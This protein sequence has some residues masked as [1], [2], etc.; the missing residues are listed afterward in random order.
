MVVH[1]CKKCGQVFTYKSNYIR[2]IN[3]KYACIEKY[4]TLCMVC[5]K[6][7]AFRASLYR[8]RKTCKET[9]DININN[10]LMTDQR[11]INNN[12]NVDGDVKVVKF[13]NENLSYISNDLYKH[14]LGRGI[15]SV[16]ELVNHTHFNE[17]HPE[18][19]NIYISNIKSNCLVLYDG[20]KWIITKHDEKL[21]DMIYAKSDFLY[22][23]FK[24]LESQM[25]PLDASKFR[26][27]LDI[28]DD[29][30]T[31]E[32][33]KDNLQLR[34]YNCRHMP[35]QIRK[36]MEKLKKAIYIPLQPVR[37]DDDLMNDIIHILENA[38]RTKLQE[39]A[40]ILNS[41]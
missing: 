4:D 29:S 22:K 34:L 32:K 15:Q 23:K 28:R 27:Y 2:H 33:I 9:R 14:I 1:K 16:E 3:R 26:K 20:D 8:H 19:H 36:H 35:Q 39:F 17:N 13:G 21:E 11:T 10:T 41:L 7:F 24:E 12:M 30:A 38:D 5:G 31:I 25:H 40:D 6:K 37:K 18:N